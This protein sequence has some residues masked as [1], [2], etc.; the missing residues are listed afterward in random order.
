MKR[1]WTALAP[2]PLGKELVGTH[3]KRIYFFLTTQPRQ[4][5][6]EPPETPASQHRIISPSLTSGET[7]EE[8]QPSRRRSALSPSPEVDLSTPE[9]DDEHSPMSS[10]ASF[11]I[12]DA[13]PS[14]FSSRRGK[15]PP[16]EGM[17]REFT[18]MAF[19]L[20][21]RQLSE[22]LKR[23][24]EL[25]GGSEAEYVR[26]ERNGDNDNG[27]DAVMLELEIDE[28]EESA[29]LRNKE[30]ADAL[31]GACEDGRLGVPHGQVG[32]FGLTSSP[33]LKPLLESKM[34]SPFDVIDVWRNPETVE[35]DELDDLFESY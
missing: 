35:L 25:G 12:S 21:S 27:E 23:E 11:S 2:C 15:S 14:T 4:P 24:S 22:A 31:F 3:P 29:A 8:D 34:V 10:S 19:T 6:P 32:M 18:Q 5:F 33:V 17:E 26:V 28:T 16:L 20:Q 1:P 7:E 13:Q 30:A 9:L